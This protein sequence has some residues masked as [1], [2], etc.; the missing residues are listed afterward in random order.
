MLTDPTQ[1]TTAKNQ[2]ITEISADCSK[3]SE[4]KQKIV[5]IFLE[6]KAVT[7]VPLTQTATS[8]TLTTTTE[9]VTEPKE[10]HKLFFHPVRHVGKQTTP[11]RNA[12]MEP[13]QPIDHLPVT[14]DQRTKSGPT[15]S[16]PK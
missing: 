9:T 5:K 4:N 10:S 16:Q 1:A 3:S 11:Q 12:T 13:M 2:G 7:P 6:T 15:K 14:E 8:T